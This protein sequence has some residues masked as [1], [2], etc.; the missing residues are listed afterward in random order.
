LCDFRVG[1]AVRIGRR[2]L[3]AGG[4][5]IADYDGHPLDAADRRAGLT[6]APDQIRPVTIG[7][8]V[9]IGQGAVILKG[10][11]IGERAVV[12]AHAVV[13][14]DVPADSVVAGNPAQ[15]VRELRP[16]ERPEAAA[17]LEAVT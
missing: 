10:V 6:S 12:G 4:V 3:I 9:W 8:D 13:T 11:T 5:T 7:D 16:R 15:V 1:R 17:M 14:R 2:V